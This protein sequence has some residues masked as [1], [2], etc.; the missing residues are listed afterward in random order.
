MS[1][2]NKYLKHLI[3]EE[4]S[5]VLREQDLPEEPA[6]ADAP[7][8]PGAPPASPDLAAGAPPGAETSDTTDAPGGPT[9]T[10]GT[11]APAAGGVPGV[12][13]AP[14]DLGVEGEPGAEGETGEDTAGGGG[15]FTGGGGGGFSFSN[16]GESG[17]TPDDE[18]E[19]ETVTTVGPE[20]VEMPDDP[21]M[22]IADE[23][24]N[25]L[26]TTR[27]PNVILKSVKSSI[28]RYFS[29]VEDATPVIKALWDSEDVVLRD[30]ARRLLLFIRGI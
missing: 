15:G 16:D 11:G 10:V 12:G 30:V 27:Q 2:Y 20:D 9:G 14:G 6:P 29:D 8:A 19:E 4:V 22:A 25:M 17:L 26:K 28:Q 13:G 21:I 7:P 5:R 1:T 24:V 18:D 3:E 23:A